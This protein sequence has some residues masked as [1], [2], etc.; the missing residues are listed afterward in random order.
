MQ[1][2]DKTILLTG[3]SGG[4]GKAGF[5]SAPSSHYRPLWGATPWQ[6]ARSEPPGVDAL[7]RE[8][9]RRRRKLRSQ[10]RLERRLCKTR[11]S[12]ASSIAR[13][14]EER[15]TSCPERS[16]R[17][18][19]SAGSRVDGIHRN[20]LSS[21]QPSGVFEG[22]SCDSVAASAAVS[23]RASPETLFWITTGSVRPLRPGQASQ[24]FPRSSNPTLANLSRC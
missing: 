20:W 6:T 19:V 10:R 14:P 21:C 18:S 4:I 23:V 12:A 15:R 7:H 8:R 17:L 22:N 9:E 3:A 11:V 24:V 2:Q 1:L 16:Q 13:V 5:G